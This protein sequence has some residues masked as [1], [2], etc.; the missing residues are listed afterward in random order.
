M[1]LRPSSELWN[2]FTNIV[3][4]GMAECKL[5][6]QRLR[7]NRSYN[8]KLHLKKV[9]N[10]RGEI[11][12]YF[13]VFVQDNLAVCKTCKRR[14]K[15]RLCNL[16][17]HMRRSHQIEVKLPNDRPTEQPPS[18]QPYDED[19]IKAVLKVAKRKMKEQIGNDEKRPKHRLCI[20]MDKNTIIRSVIGLIVEDGVAPHV[21]SSK[22]FKVLLRPMCEAISDREGKEFKMEE[23]E[24][25]RIISSMANYVR[26]DFSNDLHCRLLSIKLDTDL[27]ASQKTYCVSARFINEGV[28]QS[29]I[30]GIIDL[31]SDEQLSE[32]HIKQV[33][34]KFNIDS[35]QIVSA[36]WDN[37]KQK[38]NKLIK[39]SEYL[40]E[41]Q[42]F[43][44]YPD[45]YLGDV[46]IER[47]MGANAQ[48]CLLDLFK[49][50]SIFQTFLQC[51][52][53]AKF[54]SEESNGYHELFEQNNL[55]IPQLDS[56]WK[57]GSTYKMMH[58]LHEARHI[59]EKVKFEKF[60]QPEDQFEAN[61]ELWSF[62][63]AFSK[64]IIYLQKSIL[65]YYTEELHIGDFYSQW[66]KCKLLT[67]KLIAANNKQNI[68]L[69]TILTEMLKVIENRTKE[70]LSQD[71]FVACIFLDPRFQRTLDSEQKSIATEYL[72]KL[73]CRAKLYTVDDTE[74]LE[75]SAQLFDD[76]EDAFLNEFLSHD[77]P[78]KDNRTSDVYQKI[79]GLKLAFQMVDTNI[80]S[81]WRSQKAS[82]PEV[83]SLSTIC[84]AIPATEIYS[85]LRYS[86]IYRLDTNSNL[87]DFTKENILNIRLNVHLLDEALSQL[88][89]IN[90]DRSNTSTFS[91]GEVDIYDISEDDNS[92]TASSIATHSGIVLASS[93]VVVNPSTTII[94]SAQVAANECE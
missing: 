24:I 70:L 37:S 27:N 85:K 23:T 71:S 68:L 42:Q 32:E 10:N 19:Q 84:F 36:F 81:F 25:E 72:K 52:N 56:P 21:I 11:N 35:N 66:L 33:L 58:D 4:E 55:S 29:H 38:Y 51:R 39:N 78:V 82:E 87:S 73:W 62:I 9:H 74:S 83:Y 65:K 15:N 12:K 43:E 76:D 92:N 90:D 54:I 57:W 6:K 69:S 79:E 93:S 61:D 40:N 77:I 80:L 28:I 86:H 48:L 41:I 60:D 89:L 7:N 53:L 63:E 45:I 88:Q 16:R 64:S 91:E 22:N 46:K 2:Y 67:V 75:E 59:L 3:E 18:P 34:H 50:S 44:S 8:L 5:C 20:K 30:L 94:S 17:L 47:Y 49:N 14:L 31:K 1:A 13:D 26:N